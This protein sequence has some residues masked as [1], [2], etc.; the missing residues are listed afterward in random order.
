MLKDVVDIAVPAL[1]FF[2]MTVVGLELTAADFRR[3]AR[4]FPVVA[5]AT[6]LQFLLWPLVAVGLIAV[7]PLKPY[8]AAGLL[9]VAACPG[10]SMANFYAYLGRGHLALGV[11]LTA[12]SCLTAV[13]TMPLVLAAF[14]AW[15]DVPAV[16]AAPVPQLI[17]QLLFLLILPILIGVFV[18]R[19]WPDWPVRHG[20]TLLRLA[21]A[22]LVALITFVVAQ[23]WE[24]L[25]A[26]FAE[27]FLAV[28]LVTAVMLPAGWWAGRACA[29]A[30]AERFTLALVLV[31]RNVGVATAVAV[32]LLGRVEFAVFATAYF[33]TQVPFLVAA[34]LLF[35]LTRSPRAVPA[36]EA[37]GT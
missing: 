32:T 37:N 15:L 30:A 3:V 36:T 25:L 4:R 9:L 31:V 8:V 34:L 5:L 20:R 1:V 21:V 26:D 18:R 35:R 11:T 28:A 16:P 22:G 10:G 17:G 23:E 29:L 14:G 19:T 2:L 24:R 33:L 12:V 7:L 6:G 13:L 27:I